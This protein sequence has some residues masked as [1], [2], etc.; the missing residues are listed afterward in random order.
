M[1]VKGKQTGIA[2]EAGLHNEDYRAGF[3]RGLE[4]GERNGRKQA[5]DAIIEA[6]GLH[7]RFETVGSEP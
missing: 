7:E 5:Q 1:K 6:L 2:K 3:A 4:I